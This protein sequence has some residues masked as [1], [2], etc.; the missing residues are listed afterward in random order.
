MKNDVWGP[1][2]LYGGIGAVF[3]IGV[4][5][6]LGFGSGWITTHARMADAVMEARVA[7]YAS[8]CADDAVTGWK[9]EKRDTAL[10]RKIDAWDTRDKL[11]KR[12]AG[13]LPIGTDA[14]LKDR[15]QRRCSSDLMATAA[16]M[17]AAPPAAANAK[18]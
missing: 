17:P 2:A 5:A 10:L 14:D 12:Y 8:I 11:A 3:G 1:R 15:V 16:D 18:P 4:A 9:D 6:F 13:E 7:T